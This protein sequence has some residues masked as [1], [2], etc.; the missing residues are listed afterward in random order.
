[1]P[2]A[3]RVARR[4]ERRA[5]LLDAAVAVI[6]RDGPGASME[7]MAA[8]AG[9]TKPILYRHF[10]DREGLVAAVGEQFFGE[11]SDRLGGALGE[12]RDPRALLHDGI[13]TYVSFIEADPATYR[14]LMQQGGRRSGETITT[15]AHQIGRRVAAVLGDQLSAAGLDTGAAEPWAYG[16]VGMVHLTGDWWVDRQTIS[17]ERLVG[18]L[19]DLLWA[20]LVGGA[21]EVDRSGPGS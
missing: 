4:A 10:G 7:A 16:I 21:T 15:L 3:A 14:F 20:G 6:R 5:A 13:D 17:R 19:T 18:Y 11:V 12:D 1:V 2:S 9:V 8:A